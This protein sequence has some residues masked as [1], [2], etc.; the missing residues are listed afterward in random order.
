MTTRRLRPRPKEICAPARQQ[1]AHSLDEIVDRYID[2]YRPGAAQEIAYFASQPSLQ[3]AVEL[4]ALAVTDSGKRHPHQ[5]RIPRSVLQEAREILS[6]LPLDRCRSF[7]ELLGCITENLEQV[8]G[9]GDLTE[10][11]I[12]TRLGGV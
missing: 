10:Y 2:D 11:D 12:A 1:T 4:A 6:A 7:H 9:I 8:H 5:R 3:R